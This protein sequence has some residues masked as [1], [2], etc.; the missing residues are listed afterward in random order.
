MKVKALSAPLGFASM[1]PKS[2][3]SLPC[4]KALMMS[5]WPPWR[6]RPRE[7]DE[8][9]R[10]HAADENVAPDTAGEEIGAIAAIQLVVSD[11]F[12]QRIVTRHAI[13]V[14]LPNPIDGIAARSQTRSRRKSVPKRCAA[15]PASS[16]R[17]SRTT[18]NPVPKRARSTKLRS[19]SKDPN[20]PEGFELGGRRG[21]LEPTR[22]HVLDSAIAI[23]PR[24]RVLAI[25]SVSKPDPP[26]IVL[27]RPKPL[28]IWMLSSPEP[29]QGSKSCPACRKC[30][31]C[32]Y[33]LDAVVAVVRPQGSHCLPGRK[34]SSSP[35]PPKI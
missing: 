15:C 5:R 16:P 35:S 19:F 23:S 2:I 1:A 34:S 17:R 24:L 13:S 28:P 27:S 33:R 3:M 21:D 6:Y 31:R 32:H 10:R 8:R 11:I 29:R 22:I 9:N 20:G 14:S 4:S 30:C 7:E 26:L 18:G 25:C 12:E